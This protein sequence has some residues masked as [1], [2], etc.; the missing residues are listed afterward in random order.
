MNHFSELG[1]KHA[2]KLTHNDANNNNIFMMQENGV[3][4]NKLLLLDFEYACYNY[5]A[6][7]IANL[8]N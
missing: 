6:Y 8:L 7:D 1:K 5:P 2:M 3:K 4:T